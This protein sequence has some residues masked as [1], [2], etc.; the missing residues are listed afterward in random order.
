MLDMV[1]LVSVISPDW[2][3]KRGEEKR[4]FPVDERN[5]RSSVIRALPELASDVLL[6]DDR[7]KRE[8]DMLL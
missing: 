6:W 3:E 7:Q 1:V 8:E 5:T 2:T 4:T